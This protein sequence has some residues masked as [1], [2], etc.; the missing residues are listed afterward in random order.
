MDFLRA[1]DAGGALIGVAVAIAMTPVIE[2]AT[3]G[4]S[5]GGAEMEPGEVGEKVNVDEEVKASPWKKPEDGSG[6]VAEGPVMGMEL[7]PALDEVRPNGSAGA[8]G[9]QAAARD[10][11]LEGASSPLPTQV[12]TVRKVF[13]LLELCLFLGF[14]WFQG[15]CSK[16][17]FVSNR[18]F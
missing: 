17:F 6:A 8:G 4:R 9:G 16:C 13:S 3:S 2:V 7:W 5:D 14:D 18:I 1:V 12:S 11:L 15:K 10:A